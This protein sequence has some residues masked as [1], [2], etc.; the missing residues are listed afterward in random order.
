MVG[1]E[2]SDDGASKSWVVSLDNGDKLVTDL[3]IPTTGVIPNN[4]FIPSQFL[5]K[6]GWV[7]VDKE[8]RVQSSEGSSPLPIYAAGDITNNSMRL[9]LK[10]LEQARVVATNIKADILGHGERK[11]FDQGESVMMV[12]PIGESGGTGQI[13]GMVPFSFMVRMIKGNDYFTS[14]APTYLAGKG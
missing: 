2:A 9:A 3:Y 12:V 7:K 11:T 10:A 13:F 1:A 5:D 8:L 6:D 14:K 4:G